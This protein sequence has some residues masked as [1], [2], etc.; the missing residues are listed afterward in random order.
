MTVGS[1]TRNAA[2]RSSYL[3]M[4][5]LLGGTAEDGPPPD[6]LEK[7]EA[8]MGTRRNRRTGAPMPYTDAERESLL[9]RVLADHLAHRPEFAADVRRHSSACLKVRF[10]KTLCREMGAASRADGTSLNTF[11]LTACA[12]Y[13]GR[14]A[15]VNGATDLRGDAGED[16]LVALL[17]DEPVR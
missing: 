2:T 15:V 12:S 1:R 17:R 6:P 14:R 16:P 13:L 8:A 9:R 3:E 11:V 10:P 4:L 7:F 5:E